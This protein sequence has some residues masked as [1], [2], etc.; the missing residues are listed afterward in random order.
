MKHSIGDEEW[1]KLQSLKMVGKKRYM[2]GIWN[3]PMVGTDL[4]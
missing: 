3:N 4:S 2:F 1:A